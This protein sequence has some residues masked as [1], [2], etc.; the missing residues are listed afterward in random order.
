MQYANSNNFVMSANFHGGSEVFNYPWDDKPATTADDSWWRFVGHEFADTCHLY[1][2]SGYMTM[3]DN[4]I[5]D[6]YSWYQV[7]GGRQ[8]YMNYWHHDREVTIEIS[9]VKM[10]PAN[11]MVLYWNY[12]Y[13]SYLNFIEQSLYGIRG[14]VT[15]TATGKPLRAF[16][17]ITGHDKDSSQIYSRLPGGFYDRV[18]D[19]GSWNLTFTSPGYYT[20]TISNIN[21]AHYQGVH[22]DVQ[23][24]SLTY[25]TSDLNHGDLMIYPSPANT[26]VH[27]V[28][29]EIDSKRWRMDVLNT[30][31]ESVISTE[32]ANSGSLTHLLNV[33][34]LAGGMY[35]I[36]LSNENGIYRRQIIVRH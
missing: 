3:L 2:P 30:M 17:Y 26:D 19:Q 27:I 10:P 20:K 28:F 1:G 34:S 4:G 11:Q 18:I 8:D 5:T 29:P 35:V 36:V 33:S 21:V 31:G 7:T 13:H 32:I 16:I 25:G 12:L 15:D 14:I 24:K 23:L 9:T 6:G 22:L